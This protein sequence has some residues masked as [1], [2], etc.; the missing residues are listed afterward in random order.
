MAGDVTVAELG[1]RFDRLDNDMRERFR[2]VD[3]RMSNSALQVVPRD[4]YEERHLALRARVDR[5]EQDNYRTVQY[6]RNFTVAITAAL[7]ASFTAVAASLITAL[8]H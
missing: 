7:L 6:R 3:D 8:V 5:L 1:R 2:A 4:V